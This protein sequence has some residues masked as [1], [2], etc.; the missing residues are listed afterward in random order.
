MGFGGCVACVWQ[1]DTYH[2]Y[3][4]SSWDGLERRSVGRHTPR[5]KGVQPL[6]SHVSCVGHPSIVVKDFFFFTYIADFIDVWK[7]FLNIKKIDVEGKFV[8]KEYALN[9][10][11]SCEGPVLYCLRPPSR[12]QQSQTCETEIFKLVKRLAPFLSNYRV[13]PRTGVVKSYI[14]IFQ[15]WKRHFC[16]YIL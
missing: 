8:L 9:Y 6:V 2:G 1:T 7:D 16:P 3:C 13:T 14:T 15:Y 11:G 5:W 10:W 4:S 12:W